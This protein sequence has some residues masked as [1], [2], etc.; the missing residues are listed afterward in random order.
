MAE[1]RK[2]FVSSFGYSDPLHTRPEINTEGVLIVAQVKS[3]QLLVPSSKN[4]FGSFK[5]SNLIVDD[6]CSSHLLVF[7]DLSHMDRMF[8]SFP[9]KT[10][11]YMGGV[12]N[13]TAG[14]GATM[15]VKR[16]D[17]KLFPINFCRD[18]L[19]SA[20]NVL[21]VNMV[22]FLFGTRAELNHLVTKHGDKLSPVALQFF[23]ARLMAT[24]NTAKLT[25]SLIGF[26][27]L[28]KVAALRVGSIAYYFHPLSCTL[29]DVAR[30]LAQDDVVSQHLL[31]K[32][33]PAE[34]QRLRNDLEKEM[35]LKGRDN[36]DSS[37]LCLWTSELADFHEE[38]V[39]VLLQ[40]ECKNRALHLAI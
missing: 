21:N 15:E 19:P 13:G 17:G 28:E 33:S 32:T 16:K 14:E 9:E 5:V 4:Y 11:K 38:A 31:F 30:I 12:S 27:I 1:S 22:R 40:P 7:D 36:Y 39:P 34:L 18:L 8:D 2:R 10:H 29:L 37:V 26:N 6:G 25:Y 35:V 3:K 20:P 23:Q 24:T